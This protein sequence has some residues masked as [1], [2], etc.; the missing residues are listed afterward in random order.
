MVWSQ[1]ERQ[2]LIETTPDLHHAGISK[3]LGK[4]WRGL[5]QQEQKP[6]IQEAERLHVLHMMEYPHYKYQPRKKG[7]IKK[8]SKQK[9][10]SYIEF[11]R[12]NVYIN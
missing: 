4:R 3:H 1:I 9:M 5:S 12:K 2:K 8:V 7:K 11:L 6:F 10:L